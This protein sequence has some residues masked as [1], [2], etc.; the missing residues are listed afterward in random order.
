MYNFVLT[1]RLRHSSDLGRIST[2][3]KLEAL[4]MSL[5]IL[6]ACCGKEGWALGNLHYLDNNRLLIRKI[7]PW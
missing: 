1:N 2:E 3:I 6:E 5:D 7:G 4:A